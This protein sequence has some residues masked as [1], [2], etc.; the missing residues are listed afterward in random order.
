MPMRPMRPC[1]VPGCAALTTGGPCPQH[2]GGPS[3]S[4]AR[5]RKEA[6]ARKGDSRTFYFS[7]PWRRVRAMRLA[8]DPFCA[9]GEPA[10]TVDHKKTRRERPDLELD[11]NNTES[12]CESHHN[13]KTATHDGGF[14]NA[15]R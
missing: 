15:R 3:D 14:G 1:S 10:T 6:D 13:Q 8:L 5:A 7:K 12:K 11:L 9:C 2:K 4:L